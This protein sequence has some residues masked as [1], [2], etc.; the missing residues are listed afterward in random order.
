MEHWPT[1][2]HSMTAKEKKAS[3]SNI[4]L[5]TAGVEIVHFFIIIWQFN[6]KMKNPKQIDKEPS[7]SKKDEQEIIEQG[8]G[9]LT[10]RKRANR[11]KHRYYRGGGKM[12]QQHGALQFLGKWI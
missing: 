8:H 5:K 9:R 1:V 11:R 7:K 10:V 3:P 12:Y 4:Q 6:R 2:R